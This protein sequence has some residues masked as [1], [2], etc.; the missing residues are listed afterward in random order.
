MI[1]WTVIKKF[2]TKPNAEG[3]IRD[4]QRRINAKYYLQ[5]LLLILDP[6]EPELRWK[7]AVKERRGVSE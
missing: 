6:E 5:P 4:N 2:A 7:I 1:V 3:F